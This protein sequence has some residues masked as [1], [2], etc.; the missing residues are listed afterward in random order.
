MTSTLCG[1]NWCDPC[2]KKSECGG[3]EACGA[4]PCGGH[5]L[6]ADLVRNGGRDELQAQKASLIAEINALGF[7]DLQLDDLYCLSGFIG[8][9]TYSLFGKSIQFLNDNDVYFGAQVVRPNH[10]RCYG[11]MADSQHI[12]ICEYGE[13]GSDPKLL[14]LKNRHCM[15]TSLRTQHPSA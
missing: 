3:C 5:C 1:Q 9:L 2:E 11:I 6:A 8:N 12:L 15:P 7:E 4:S 14:L 10:A 13:N